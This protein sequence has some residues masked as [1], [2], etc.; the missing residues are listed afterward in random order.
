MSKLILGDCAE[1]L[2]DIPDHSV[3]AVIT[4]PPFGINFKYNEY[5]DVAENYIKWLWPILETC[6]EKCKPGSPVFVW[7]AT[8]NLK[9]FHEWFPRDW[10]MFI[11]A[12]NF[13]QIRHTLMNYSYDPILAWWTPGEKP[14][15]EGKRSR[16]YF[17]C[18]TTPGAYKKGYNS[19]KGHPCPRPLDV[20]KLIIQE[21]VRP[22][23]VVLDPF[24]GSGTAGVASVLTG[25]DFIGIEL[26]E[27]YFNLATKRIEETKNPG[28]IEV[29]LLI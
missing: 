1:A 23:G 5:K 6:E 4:D 3:D 12:K 20:V 19:A 21:W 2:K 17:L 18:D 13:I 8:K 27:D 22:G 9:K 7:Q 11:A 15:S 16:D 29:P 25:R 24:M 28:T 26:N 14:Y 10:R